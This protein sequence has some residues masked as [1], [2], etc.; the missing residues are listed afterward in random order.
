[1]DI[2]HNTQKQQLI[3]WYTK[4]EN[5]WC[6]FSSS[7]IRNKVKITG[8]QQK[9]TDGLQADI[10]IPRQ[11]R[12]YPTTDSRWLYTSQSV[13]WNIQTVPPPDRTGLTGKW[14]RST[15]RLLMESGPNEIR[16]RGYEFKGEYDKGGLECWTEHKFLSESKSRHL[17]VESMK[18]LIVY[19]ELMAL[20]L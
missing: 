18:Q 20:F 2:I 15:P 8:R 6:R 3:Q 11:L 1:M 16:G 14:N 12:K 19:I 9:K 4:K 13:N 10:D 7:A 5:L 17:L